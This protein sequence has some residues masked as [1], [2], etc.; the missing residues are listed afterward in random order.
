[1]NLHAVLFDL[2]G[3]LLDYDIRETFIPAYFRLLTARLA[4]YVPPTRLMSAMQEGMAAIGANDGRRTNEE[5]F[6]A[7]FYPLVERP[8]EELEPVFRAFYTQ[9]FPELQRHVERRP[10]ARQVI[11]TAFDLGYDVVIATN[12]FFPEIATRQRLEWAGVAD[13]PFR[14]VT[15]YENSHAAKPNALYFQEILEELEREPEEALMVGDEPMDMAAAHVGC[16]T[17]LVE[18][19]ANQQ[20]EEIEP[21]PTYQGNLFDLEELLKKSKR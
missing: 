14:K 3:T 6:T 10:G 9:D 15:T 21:S 18:G 7:A 5:A 11:Q 17:F 12:P 16:P 4:P 20:D 2:D 1:M 8:R 13:F 19:P